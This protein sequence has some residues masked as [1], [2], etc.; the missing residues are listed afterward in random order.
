MAYEVR[1]AGNS[2][3]VVAT[4]NS[5]KTIVRTLNT[6]TARADAERLVADLAGWVL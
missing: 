2:F 6:F 5:G 4:I 1:E 3:K